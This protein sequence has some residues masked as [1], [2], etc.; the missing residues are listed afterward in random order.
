MHKFNNLNVHVGTIIEF[1]NESF[2]ENV[3]PCKST[4]ETSSV[5]RTF[6]TA[7]GIVKT[8]KKKILMNLNRVKILK[9]QNLLVRK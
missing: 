6:E 1:R 8:K 5:K 9:Y 4:Q 7:I 2:F 3:F